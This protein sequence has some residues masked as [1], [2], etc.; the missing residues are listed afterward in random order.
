MGAALHP[1][2]AKGAAQ[3]KTIATPQ[4][5]E[6]IYRALDGFPRQENK[7]YRDDRE[8]GGFQGNCQRQQYRRTGKFPFT[9]QEEGQQRQQCHDRIKLPPGGRHQQ[10]EWVEQEKYPCPAHGF[11][12]GAHFSQY[13]SNQECQAD[14]GGNDRELDR[15]VVKKNVWDKLIS[16]QVYCPQHQCPGWKISQRGDSLE[17]CCYG[18]PHS[19][20]V[21]HTDSDLCPPGSRLP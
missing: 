13:R 1:N 8:G 14:V 2:R 19:G 9:D 10:E 5:A 18:R 7:Y 6:I 17:P 15:Q 3:N 16:E 12:L 11:F 20:L 4:T 21:P